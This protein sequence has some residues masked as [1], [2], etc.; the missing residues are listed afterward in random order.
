MSK[1]RPVPTVV[2]SYAER[3]RVT[4]ARAEQMPATDMS[5]GVLPSVTHDESR[6]KSSSFTPLDELVGRI[7][8]C[9]AGLVSVKPR[10]NMRGRNVSQMDA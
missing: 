10:Q 9:G 5:E 8:G 3:D 4:Q 1:A 6:V 7:E 2:Q